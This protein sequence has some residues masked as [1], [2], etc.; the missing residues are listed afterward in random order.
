MSMRIITKHFGCCL[1]HPIWELPAW[2]KWCFSLGFVHG[3]GA[4]GDRAYRYALGIDFQL[5][6]NF[7]WYVDYLGVEFG[8][9][10]FNYRIIGI[11]GWP[12]S[13]WFKRGR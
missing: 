4:P 1:E 10:V 7:V 3:S 5:I 9:P 13:A 12:F 8:R 2:H 11:D 6:P